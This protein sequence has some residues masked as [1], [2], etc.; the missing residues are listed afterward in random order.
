L[1]K[2]NA[3]RYRNI[4]GKNLS[5]RLNSFISACKDT[6]S[7]AALPHGRCKR[8]SHQLERVTHLHFR[9]FLFLGRGAGFR[10]VVVLPTSGYVA[11]LLVVLRIYI[12]D[13]LPNQDD[14]AFL[15]EL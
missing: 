12:T 15:V 2:L 6:P 4:T 13:G 5:K 3:L 11:F 8:F 14:D 1:D 10:I 9:G 7:V